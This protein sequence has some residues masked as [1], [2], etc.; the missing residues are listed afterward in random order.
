[1]EHDAVI[2]SHQA[3]THR[4]LKGSQCSNRGDVAIKYIFLFKHFK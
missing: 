1:M 4:I 3:Q 2:L